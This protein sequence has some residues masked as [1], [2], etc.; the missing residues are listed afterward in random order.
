L[1]DLILLTH[2]FGAVSTAALC[3]AAITSITFNAHAG[4]ACP[5]DINN[6]GTVNADDLVMVI[7]SWGSCAGTCPAD[8]APA[9]GN[10]IV[11]ADDLIGVIMDWGACSGSGC[12]ASQ[13]CLNG[14]SLWCENFELANYSRWSMAY[15]Q[16]TSCESN[17]FSFEQ[18][19]SQA[20]S[21]KSRVMCATGDSHRGYGCLR[22]QGDTVMPSI[23]PSSGGINAPHGVVVTMWK[24]LDVPYTFSS[25][26]WISLMTVT[27]DCSNNWNSVLT[28]NIDDSSMRLK[29]VHVTSVSYASNAPAFP[30]RQWTRI[31]AYVNYHTGSMHVWQ[32]GVKVCSATFSRSS[33]NMC[34]WHFGLYASGANDNITLFEDDYSIVKLNEPMTNFSVEPRFPSLV[35]P[36]G[37]AP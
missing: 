26:R 24:W 21:H 9:G 35:S 27:H 11:N 3:A 4:G 33:P 7:S 20:R 34:Q 14:T 17:G 1:E 23:S 22:F 15:Y 31:T 12:T 2:L 13:G 16:T 37:I 18:A 5:P 8:I 28:L 10:G 36:C 6:N 32:N 25:S 19:R 30:L 29:P